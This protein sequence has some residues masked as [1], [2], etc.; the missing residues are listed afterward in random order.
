M[1][2]MLQKKR[3][4]VETSMAKTPDETKRRDITMRLQS[5][6]NSPNTRDTRQ[7]IKEK[8]GLTR[9]I[10][11]ERVARLKREWQHQNAQRKTLDIQYQRKSKSFAAHKS[12]LQEMGTFSGVSEVKP[13][14][15]QG[16]VEEALRLQNMELWRKDSLKMMLEGRILRL[17][18]SIARLRFLRRVFERWMITFVQANR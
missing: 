5:E 12:S 9:S 8:E 7:L 18:I 3:H 11:V 2:R 4:H 14:R 17:K 10:L 16:E 6:L 13:Q 1:L 15:L